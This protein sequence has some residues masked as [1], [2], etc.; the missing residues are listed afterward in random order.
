MA[1]DD[2]VVVVADIDSRNRSKRHAVLRAK[3]LQQVLEMVEDQQI[4]KARS[5]NDVLAHLTREKINVGE[6]KETENKGK[7]RYI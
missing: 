2:G 7:D 6:R 5:H 4:S 3:D 1:A